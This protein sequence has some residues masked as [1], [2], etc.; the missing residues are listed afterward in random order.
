VRRR[1]WRASA[2]KKGGKK[3]KKEFAELLVYSCPGT[4]SLAQ[5]D[6]LLQQLI[7]SMHT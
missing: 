1:V 6:T 3:K 7:S 4:E 5:A 2:G